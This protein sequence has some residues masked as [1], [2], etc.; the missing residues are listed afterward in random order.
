MNDAMIS[1]SRKK[2]GLKWAREVE[3]EWRCASDDEG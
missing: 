3:P 2:V 1:D